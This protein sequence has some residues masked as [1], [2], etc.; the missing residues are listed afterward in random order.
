VVAM[1]GLHESLFA[2]SSPYQK[3]GSVFLVDQAGHARSWVPGT[4]GIPSLTS[5]RFGW[6]IGGLESGG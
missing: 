3:A 6:N 2:I 4:A 1:K 5:G